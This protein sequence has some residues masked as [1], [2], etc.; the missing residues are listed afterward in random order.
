VQ[1][2][3]GSHTITLSARGTG[4]AAQLARPAP[5][6]GKWA[7]EEIWSFAS[8]DLLRIAA[9]EGADG[10][11]PAQANVPADWLSF[12]AFRMDKDSKLSI[13]ERSRGIANADDNQL[14]MTRNLWLDFDHGGFTAIDQIKGTL[15]RDWRLNMQ[16]P[17]ALASARQGGDQLLVTEGTSGASGVELRQP[18]LSLTT[19]ARKA[20][21]SAMPATGWDQRFDRVVGKLHLPPG[22]RLIAALGADAAPQSWWEQWALWNVFGVVLVVAFVFWTA[23]LVPA[24]I[25]ALALALT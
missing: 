13:V 16:T 18:N 17:Y 7:R 6:A 15:R 9:A 23:G 11:D 12:P 25:A 22:H 5:G 4:V 1:V 10:I 14:S 8:N 2:R 19:V 21:G 20:A 24:A 3:P